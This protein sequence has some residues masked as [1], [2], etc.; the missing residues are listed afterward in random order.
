MAFLI[1]PFSRL[2]NLVACVAIPGSSR[3][4]VIILVVSS[5]LSGHSHQWTLCVA[6]TKLFLDINYRINIIN[7]ARGGV[8]LMYLGG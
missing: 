1:I 6:V 4:V 2:G 5:W 3:L 7:T 8:A